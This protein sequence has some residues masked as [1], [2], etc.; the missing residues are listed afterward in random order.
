MKK[1]LSG[2]CATGL[3]LSFAA[4]S[5][6]PAQAAPMA[7]RQVETSSDVVQVRDRNWNNGSNWNNGGRK[8][9]KR[10]NNRGWNN[11][12]DN[13]RHYR[14]GRYYRN[15]NN[16]NGAGIAAGVIAGALITGA[17]V[18][19]QQP[20]AVYNNGGGHVQWCYNRY[21]SYRASDNPY[22]GPRQQC[23]SPY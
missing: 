10:Y 2:L 12:R 18:N 3:A 21:R 23:Y 5:F 8:Y 19:S 15:G 20:R 17:I 22:N 1:W 13:Y 14:N 9:Y 7:P 4:T 16:Y 11:N 6:A